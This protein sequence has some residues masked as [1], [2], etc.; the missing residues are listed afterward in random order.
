MRPTPLIKAF[1]QAL[2]ARIPATQDANK[3]A[4][5]SALCAEVAKLKV[6]RR[7]RGRLVELKLAASAEFANS[8]KSENPDEKF[9]T[10]LATVGQNLLQKQGS[11]KWRRGESNPRP[12][13]FRPSTLRA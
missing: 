5:G 8:P 11:M 3:D 2:H 13:A 9:A 1:R 10:P 7:P 6:L 4:T 12:K